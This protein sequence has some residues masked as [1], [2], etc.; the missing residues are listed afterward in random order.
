MHVCRCQRLRS[1]YMVYVGH[2]FIYDRASASTGTTR[3]LHSI[4]V[5]I[6][7]P[8]SKFGVSQRR[9]AIEGALTVAVA[10][11]GSNTPGSGNTSTRGALLLSVRCLPSVHHNKKQGNHYVLE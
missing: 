3:G 8:K 2:A 4:P 9:L 1:L 10:A 6:V 7:D 11:L 5:P